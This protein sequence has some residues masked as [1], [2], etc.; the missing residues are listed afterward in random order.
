MLVHEPIG[1]C[2]D[3]IAYVVALFTRINSNFI[4]EWYVN[5]SPNRYS[6]THRDVFEFLVTSA[7]FIMP[8]TK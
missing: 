2:R 1:V 7:D 3:L 5:F 4:F 8:V 6:I